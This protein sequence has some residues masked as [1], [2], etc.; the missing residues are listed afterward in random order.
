MAKKTVF[1]RA[2]ESMEADQAVLQ[3]AI[4]RLR[5]QQKKSTTARL[6]RTPRAATR[7]VMNLAPSD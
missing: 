1:E 4:D 6:A 3:A 2:I 5:Q 7:P